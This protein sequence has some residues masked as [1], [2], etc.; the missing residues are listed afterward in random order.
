MPRFNLGICIV[1]V[2]PSY[3][4]FS[5][6]SDSIY[7]RNRRH[8]LFG[9]SVSQIIHSQVKHFA[10]EAS[11]LRRE[12]NMRFTASIWEALSSLSADERVSMFTLVQEELTRR[13]AAIR[14]AKKA[15]K[16]LPPIPPQPLPP[17]PRPGSVIEPTVVRNSPRRGWLEEAEDRHDEIHDNFQNR[18]SA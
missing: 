1:C 2:I 11:R 17:F 15:E 16:S 13:S 10:D 12:H 5:I 6:N 8:T 7:F 3:L 4:T 18:D 9:G 14:S